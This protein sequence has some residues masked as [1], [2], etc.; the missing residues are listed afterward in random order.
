M[1][2]VMIVLGLV[3]LSC[4]NSKAEEATRSKVAKSI[5]L[6]KAPYMTDRIK[7]IRAASRLT[8]KQILADF[9]IVDSLIAT[10]ND[11]S[12]TPNERSE[13]MRGLV[14]LANN[15][16]IDGSILIENLAKLIASKK[17][18]IEVRID[19]LY[20]L[21]SLGNVKGKTLNDQ[22]FIKKVQKMI[23][24]IAKKSSNKTVLRCI[25]FKVLGSM[26][27]KGAESTF[28]EV[29]NVEKKIKIKE[30]A[31]QGLQNYVEISGNSSQK[32]MNSI[33]N[34]VVKFDGKKERKLRLIGI[35]TIEQF[36]ANG[37]NLIYKKKVAKFLFKTL[38]DGDDEEMIASSQCL[39]RI[40]DIDIVDPFI[41]EIKKKSRGDKA[42]LSLVKGAIELLGPFAKTIANTTASTKTKNNAK[43]DAEK[44][45]NKILIPLVG[46][47]G[48]DEELRLTAMIGVTAIP[49][50]ISRE[51]VVK[52]IISTLS[53]NDS[54]SNNKVKEEA[55]KALMQI[56]RIE[57]P[58]ITKDKKIDANAWQEWFKDNK[59]Y[60][61]AG[62]APWD[63]EN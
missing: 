31:I 36:L 32:T 10:A 23:K 42:T 38:A 61:K 16:L 17:T 19:A 15:Q 22:S 39:I 46:N 11:N 4:I 45:I 1:K 35:R 20:V 5:K 14:T 27:G 29:L 56:S 6:L 37:T 34:I 24:D 53:K 48:I 60:L 51:N 58:F 7:G 9:K 59:N 13:A 25:A 2:K 57:K 8:D 12:L 33:C 28:L 62:K 40:K 44:I 41:N 47:S 30:A 49:R 52:T 3:I 55:V 43:S 63:R 26:A 21:G 18:D 54:K 50:A